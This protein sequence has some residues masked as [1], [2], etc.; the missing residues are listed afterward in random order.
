MAFPKLKKEN[1][2]GKPIK[3]FEVWIVEFDPALGQR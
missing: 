3:Q 2:H 1:G